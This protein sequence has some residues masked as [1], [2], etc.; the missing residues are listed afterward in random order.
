[1]NIPILGLVE[2]MSY[3]VCPECN[4]RHFIYGESHV[5]ELAASFGIPSFARLPID[6]NLAK[7]VDAGNIDEYDSPEIDSLLQEIQK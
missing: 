5:E 3:F 1:M 2:N 7:T 6:P 4:K